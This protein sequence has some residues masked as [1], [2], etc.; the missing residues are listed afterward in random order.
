MEIKNMAKVICA[1]T[2]AIGAAAFVGYQVGKKY[3]TGCIL[4]ELAAN[5]LD[6]Q[7]KTNKKK[8]E[9]ETKETEG[10]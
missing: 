4:M 9:E 6:E 10:A 3:G 5:A 1:L 2:G 8:E 7:V